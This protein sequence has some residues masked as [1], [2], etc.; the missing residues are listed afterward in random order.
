MY[1]I[2]K[3][4]GK[5]IWIVL[6]LLV[7][8]VLMFPYFLLQ[9]EIYLPVTDNLDS[10]LSWWKA[11][12]DQG[13]IWANWSDSVGGMFLQNPRFTYP[14]GWNLDGILY[15]LFS[16]WLAYGVQKAIIFWAA[17]FSFLLWQEVQELSLSQF[18]KVVFALAWATLSFYPHR[19]I[20]IAALPALVAV[21]QMIFQGERKGYFFSIA[22]LYALGSKLVLAGFYFWIG[23]LFYSVWKCIQIKDVKVYPFLILGII[24]L[25]WIGQ[26]YALIQGVFF[27]P[28]FQSQREDFTYNFGIWSN[29]LPLDFIWNGDQNGVFYS[30]AYPILLLLFVITLLILR[31][32]LKG[33]MGWNYLLGTISIAV[34][35]SAISFSGNPSFLGKA[36]PVLASFNWFRFEYWI[37][38][39]LFASLVFFWER[40]HFKG[41]LWIMPIALATNVF[42]YHYEWRYWINESISILPRVPSYHSYYSESQFDEIKKELGDRYGDY[43]FAH[44]NLPPAVSVFNGLSTL[45]GYSQIYDR[46]HKL[47]VYKVIG[48]ELEKDPSLKQH[49]LSWGNKCYFQN[50]QYPDDYVMYKWRESSPLKNPEFDFKYLK[51]R[52]KGDFVLSSLPV[53]SEY[54]SIKKVYKNSDGAWDIYW[55]EIKE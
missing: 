53:Q 18:Q 32:P 40:L 31:S 19:G 49:F 11:L 47:E 48:K 1:Q 45:D 30:P 22:I 34:L 44:L 36:F 26:E 38:F 15:F 2:Q 50:A 10:N 8:L 13:L 27:N 14:S 21:S 51:A 3:K 28:G 52:M 25:I 54:L 33:N 37:P 9:E 43:R 35:L 23:L 29:Q 16:P 7:F 12:K 20:S 46:K 41:F 55:Y 24:G 5:A 17:L 4:E 39:F 42:A 6:C